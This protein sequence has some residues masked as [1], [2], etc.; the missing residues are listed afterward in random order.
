MIKCPETRYHEELN[1]KAEAARRATIEAYYA[2]NPRV[3]TWEKKVIQELRR[4]QSLFRPL[5]YALTRNRTPH[6]DK[7][8]GVTGMTTGEIVRAY[9]R[10]CRDLQGARLR[11]EEI[12]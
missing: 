3:R 4:V 8:L 1:R 6:N 2:A 10:A 11:L 7:V 9:E 12:R 5:A